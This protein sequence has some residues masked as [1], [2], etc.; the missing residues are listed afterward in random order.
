MDA[1]HLPGNFASTANALEELAFAAKDALM[2]V[3]DFVPTG[4]PADGAL[5]SLAER[6][7]RSAGNRH[8]RSRMGGRQLRPPRPP[9]GLLLATGEE[10]P[11]GQS[12]RARLL[13]VELHA[14]E[15]DR[16]VLEECQNSGRSGLLATAMGAFLSWLAGRYDQFR[17]D[18]L[19]RVRELRREYSGAAHSRLPGAVANLQS[20]FEVWLKFAN[21][22]GAVDDVER[23]NLKE[24]GQRAFREL[25]DLQVL[26]HHAGDPALRFVS[27]L[28]AALA[29]GRAHMANRGGAPPASPATYGWHP[30]PSGL[31]W[32][33]QGA[34]IGWLAGSNL[35]LDPEISYMVAQQVAGADRLPIGE[36]ALRHRLHQR[37][38]LV[39]IDVGRKMLQVRRTLEGQ[40]R[41]VLHLRVFDLS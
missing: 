23:M 36:Q 38:L 1:G 25:L 27:L 24:R 16:T 22:V 13:A 15:V 29:T 21:E 31:G 11:R 30:K 14:G 37:G 17:R 18:H 4:G 5:H 12:L 32:I 9:R 40:P 8:G 33:P 7:F 2:V 26:Y 20:G 19:D 35:F 34:R 10:V 41:Q 6:L 28:R 3:D 39:S